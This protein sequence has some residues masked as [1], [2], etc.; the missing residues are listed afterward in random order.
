MDLLCNHDVLQNL[1][2]E[3]AEGE[4]EETVSC[5]CFRQMEK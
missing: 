3:T 1:K 5:E 4:E 2:R